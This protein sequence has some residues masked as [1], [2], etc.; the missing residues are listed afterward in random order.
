MAMQEVSTR[1]GAIHCM[2]MG[3]ALTIQ[4]HDL[5][6]EIGAPDRS[7]TCDPWLR[8]PILYP[9]ELRARDLKRWI[10]P[11]LTNPVQKVKCRSL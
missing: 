2:D 10:I 9:T 11:D 8:K 5:K 6:S 1:T 3:K 4:S 7:R